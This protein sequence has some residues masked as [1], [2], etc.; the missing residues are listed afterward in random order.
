MALDP[1]KLSKTVEEIIDR[2]GQSRDV[3]QYFQDIARLTTLTSVDAKAL[4][5]ALKGVAKSSKEVL[6]NF[7][8][9]SK[10]A[11][12]TVEAQ[13]DLNKSLKANRV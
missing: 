10:G 3:V 1:E 11:K 12:S 4:Q 9:A 6:Q 7:Q 13:K 2:L 8:D 5:D